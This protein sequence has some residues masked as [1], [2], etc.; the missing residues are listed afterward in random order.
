MMKSHIKLHRGF[1]VIC[2]V[3]LLAAFVT[4]AK[5]SEGADRA[6]RNRCLQL[7]EGFKT[8][9]RFDVPHG[10]DRV[11]EPGGM[12]EVVKSPQTL[13]HPAPSDVQRL[14]AKIETSPT[15]NFEILP[16]TSM[17]ETNVDGGK[18]YSRAHCDGLSC[19]FKVAFVPSAE[20]GVAA[21]CGVGP[22]ELRIVGLSA[23]GLAAAR[24]AIHFHWGATGA[25]SL[26]ELAP[27]S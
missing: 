18:V 25:M 15:D 1:A 13:W 17:R 5:A 7:L 11:S 23:Q 10:Y 16:L 21:E 26:A 8:A 14:G 4:S 27:G 6:R 9:V 3:S 22:A 19:L 24:R 12:V 20:A 2:A